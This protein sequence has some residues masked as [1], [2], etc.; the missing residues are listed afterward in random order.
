MTITRILAAALAAAAIATPSALARAA[1]PPTWPAHPQPITASPGAPTWPAHPQ[2]IAAP[3]STTAS[4]DDGDDTA[5]IAI[6]I[7]GSA[8]AA[9]ALGG[10]ASHT[11]RIRR[12]RALA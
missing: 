5:T 12:R 1:A 2:P 10:L 9:G 3:A 8:L 4:H 7:A 6:A 11:R